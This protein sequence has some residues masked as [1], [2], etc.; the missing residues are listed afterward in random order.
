[1]ID[2]IARWRSEGAE[3]ALARV[4]KADGSSPRE[5]GATMAINGDGRVA[6][7]VSGGC[8]ESAVVEAALG[9][10]ATRTPKWIDFGYSDADAFAVGLTCGGEIGIFI[11][12][13]VP[14]FHDELV[15][16][17]A[18]H[19]AVAT[20]TVVA[21]EPRAR[22]RTDLPAE[23]FAYR[24]DVDESLL[25]DAS[26]DLGASVL[27]HAD[28]T[29]SGSLGQ[30]S[31]DRTVI[32]DARGALA[33]GRSGLRTY[34]VHGEERGLDLTV[35][36]DAFSPPPEMVIFGAVDFTAALA[37]AAKLLG[38]IVTVCDARPAFATRERFPMADEVVVDWPQRFLA[39]RGA[40]LGP[41]DAI[42]VLTHDAKFDV[43]AIVAATGT[44]VGYI[45]AMGSR[46]THNDRVERLIEAGLD[47]ETI[48][49]VRAPIGID[50]GARTP[51]EVAIAICAEIIALRTG[52]TPSFLRDGAG[53]IH[54]T[55]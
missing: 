35:F 52:R 47:S 33:A 14:E 5:I 34:G 42:C 20:A 4:I 27:I 12:P 24:P 25:T 31:L 18:S 53:P 16:A 37:S 19:S 8:I 23:P 13:G 2:D 46:R 43:P 11:S 36:I 55:H 50:L 44:G 54:A 38:Y 6:G 30:A 28:G 1:V 21:V 3:I 49:R 9:V 17:L 26:V 32:H 39:E 10:L 7:S 48:A 22:P 40:T 41:E 51:E 15:E 45:G 29:V